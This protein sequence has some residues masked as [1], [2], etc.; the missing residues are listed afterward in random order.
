[1]M[2][3][4]TINKILLLLSTLICFSILVFCSSGIV[5]ADE[6]QKGSSANGYVL[7]MQCA[8]AATA[9]EYFD[10]Y[11]KTLRKIVNES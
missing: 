2:K 5:F 8:P 4:K 7:S 9:A 3:T 1:M 11:D 6:I 10:K